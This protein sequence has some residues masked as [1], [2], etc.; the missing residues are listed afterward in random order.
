MKI[1]PTIGRM[2]D[3]WPN[4][5]LNMNTFDPKQPF[6]AQVVYVWGDTMVNLRVTDHAGNSQPMSS[7]RLINEGDVVPVDCYYCSWMPYQVHVARKDAA[8]APDVVT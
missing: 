2:V 6:A 1:K 5:M 7:V 4:G 3:F 8:E